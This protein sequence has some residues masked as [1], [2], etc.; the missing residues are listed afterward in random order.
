MLDI[1]DGISK[2]FA[3]VIAAE[4]LEQDEG[5]QLASQDLLEVSQNI[6]LYFAPS[7]SSNANKLVVLP[8]DPQHIYAYWHLNDNPEKSMSQRMLN[9]ELTLRVYSQPEQKKQAVHISPLVEIPIHDFDSRHRIRLPEAENATA[10][11]VSIEAAVK[12]NDFVSLIDSNNTY[13]FQGSLEQKERH[14][15]EGY[16]EQYDDVETKL[17]DREASRKGSSSVYASLTSSAKG[18]KR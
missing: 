8:I 5:I 9:D 11:S 17:I 13:T 10:Y 16:S 14:E 15:T 3:P 1:S 2:S 7:M 18:K 4:I 12:K 6:S